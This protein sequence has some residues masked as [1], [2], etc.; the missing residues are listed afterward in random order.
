MRHSGRDQ[1]AE[2]AAVDRFIQRIEAR[3]LLMRFNQADLVIAKVCGRRVAVGHPAMGVMHG[4]ARAN[5]VPVIRQHSAACA[6]PVAVLISGQAVLRPPM[7]P[8]LFVP[9]DGRPRRAIAGRI[10]RKDKVASSTPAARVVRDDS[11]AHR[12]KNLGNSRDSLREPVSSKL[13]HVATSEGSRSASVMLKSTPVR[14][15]ILGGRT[16]SGSRSFRTDLSGMR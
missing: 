1:R 16:E 3:E 14:V 10:H 2:A 15:M 11:F 9:K 12:I 7:I 6:I 13:R 5:G 8:P 4:T